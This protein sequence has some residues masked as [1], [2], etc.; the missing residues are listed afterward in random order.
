MPDG[1]VLPD[2]VEGTVHSVGHVKIEVYVNVAALGVVHTQY[3]TPETGATENAACVSA[4]PVADVM[5]TGVPPGVVLKE[6]EVTVELES[7]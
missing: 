5:L 6:N 3:V 7:T 1:A 2:T 4:D